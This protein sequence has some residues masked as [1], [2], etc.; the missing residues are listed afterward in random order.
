VRPEQVDVVLVRPARPQNVAAAA[1]ALKNMGVSRLALVDAPG[2]LD[3]E[4]RAIAYGAWDVLDGARQ[5][6]RLQQAV[7]GSAFVV[8]ASARGGA[9]A[10]T[11]RQLA[12]RAAARAGGSRMA[13]V[14]GPEAS[15]LSSAELQLCHETVTIPTRVRQPSLNLAQAVLLILYEL[16]LSPSQAPAPSAAPAPTSTLEAALEELRAGLLA[17]GYLNPAN[18]EAI[19]AELR[20]LLGRAGATEREASLLRGMARQIAWAGAE[21][22]RLRAAK[23]SA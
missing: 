23:E 13:V 7:A 20:R 15:G 8:G 9:G 14:F 4:A 11:P 18:P 21:L 1:R 22:A 6:A 17:I 5:V 16:Q 3:A 2:G 19:L 12:E 10:W